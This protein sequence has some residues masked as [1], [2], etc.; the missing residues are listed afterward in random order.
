MTYFEEKTQA[1]N[2]QKSKKNV[3]DSIG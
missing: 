3:T 2:N 1:L